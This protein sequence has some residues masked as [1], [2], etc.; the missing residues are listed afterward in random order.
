MSDT[1]E[2]N[3]PEGTSEIDA[4]SPA[5]KKV[6]KKKVAKKKVA[7]KKV[8]K[9]KVAKKK[10]AK[11]K[12]AKKSGPT[13]PFDILGAQ[14]ELWETTM[15]QL[16][17]AA[18]ERA[19]PL[20]FKRMRDLRQEIIP[21]DHLAM[22]FLVGSKGIPARSIILI[23]GREG[24]GKST[25]GH[26]ILGSAMRN[27]GCPC[28]SIYWKIKPFLPDRAIR[29]YSNVPEQASIML[30]RV[31]S[32]GVS[33]FAMLVSTIEMWVKK[34]RTI[35][36]KEQ[37]LFIMV[38]NWAKF[39]A[40]AEAKGHVDWGRHGK[41]DA[42]GNAPTGKE[43][44]TGSKLGTSQ[45]A[46]AWT[47]FLG[48]F[49]PTNNV[50][51]LIV[52]DQNDKLT[53][54]EG[55]APTQ[56]QA[57]RMSPTAQDLRNPTHKGGR[58]LRQTASV[59]LISTPVGVVTDSRGFRGTKVAWRSHKS[60]LSQDGRQIEI[61]LRK[62]HTVYDAPGYIDPAWHMDE[63]LARL[64]VSKNLLGLSV[65]KNRYTSAV[66][67]V[68]S[69][70]DVEVSQKLHARPDLMEQVG[71]YFKINGYTNIVDTLAHGPEMPEQVL[72]EEDP[73]SDS[74]IAAAFMG[75]VEYESIDEEEV[76]IE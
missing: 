12:V 50:T 3:E 11:K 14:G 38:D 25:M 31:M 68:M 20:E 66:L 60:N 23:I 51:M 67:G 22:Q 58:A 76:D 69:V 74:A 6:A 42:K 39:L 48:H 73:D 15:E 37:G 7:K 5:K 2:N 47:E 28:L 16:K 65:L 55:G 54:S 52:V 33:T 62:D 13:G 1:N 4:D 40:D 45:F 56:Q 21:L 72:G 32:V 26:L 63:F 70:T 46:H 29:A 57:T 35:V 17:E 59:V 8:T 41:S 34:A 24:I 75:A 71:N 61:E 36:P 30:D 18:S 43:I 44:G 27:A 10:V 9:K 19:A 53:M 49:L 64:L